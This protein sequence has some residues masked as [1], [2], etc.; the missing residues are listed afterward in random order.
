MRIRES[1]IRKI[2]YSTALGAIGLVA[3]HISVRFST[4]HFASS[5]SY[6][7]VVAN[8]QTLSYAILLELILILVSVHGF[9]GLRGIFLD[10]RSGFKYEKMV[11]WGCFIAAVSL[12]AY[13]TATIILANFI[14]LYWF[15]ASK[16][17]KV[18]SNWGIR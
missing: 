9:N 13:G 7:F 14:E 12:I 18:S 16:F 6:E 3:L 11:N 8:Y 15:L 17:G 10:Y 4:G 2:H 1:H 5:L